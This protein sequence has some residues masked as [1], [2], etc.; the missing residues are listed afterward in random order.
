MLCS[1]KPRADFISILPEFYEI[2]LSKKHFDDLCSERTLFDVFEHMS[3][4]HNCFQLYLY[5]VDNFD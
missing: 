3:R 5:S 4:V 1:T 2:K